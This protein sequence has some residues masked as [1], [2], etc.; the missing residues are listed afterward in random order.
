MFKIEYVS[1]QAIENPPFKID[2]REGSY[3]Y[4]FFHFISAV[5]I[6]IDNKVIQAEPGTC[7]LYT[8]N[9][10]QLFYVED[11]RLN[12]DFIDFVID[13]PTFFNEIHLPLNIPFKP[14]CS[15]YISE[16][17]ALI[18]KEKNS[19]EL[20]HSYMLDSLLLELFTT[21]SRKMHHHSIHYSDRY[22]TNLKLQFEN[23]RL[24]IYQKPDNCSISSIAS[25][26]GFSLP[27]FNSLYKSYFDTTPIKDLTKAR[28]SRVE[29]L[30]KNGSNTQ[31]IIKR[32][33]FSSEEYF[34]RWFKKNFNMTK[35]QYLKEI[36]DDTDQTH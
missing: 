29:E 13:D 36:K 1:K 19:D 11:N 33:G 7:I 5:N 14:K 16:K 30:L 10:K 22:K 23:L 6:V 34:Y 17:M 15:P 4:I 25:D 28:I 24:E 35:E 21:L 3:R 8:P 20:G 12:H 9:V 32:I 26:M 18:I 31:E 27:R 2:R